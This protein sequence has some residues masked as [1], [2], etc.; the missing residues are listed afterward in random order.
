MK[1]NK[2]MWPRHERTKKSNIIYRYVYISLDMRV[3][4]R[5][6]VQTRYKIVQKWLLILLI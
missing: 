1:K 2:E 6:Q 4:A 3:R 5:T